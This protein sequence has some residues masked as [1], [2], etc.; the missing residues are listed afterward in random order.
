MMNYYP[1]YNDKVRL[2]VALGPVATMKYFRS[3]ARILVPFRKLTLVSDL[4]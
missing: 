3:I 1:A 4:S 2:M